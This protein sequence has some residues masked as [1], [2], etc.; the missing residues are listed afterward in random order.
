M[1]E[2]QKKIVVV[3]KEKA[4]AMTVKLSKKIKLDNLKLDYVV[5]IENGGLNVS[6]PLAKLLGIPHKSIKISFYNKENKANSE[7][8]VDFH[9]HKFEKTDRVLVVDDLIDDGHT[10]NYFENNVNCRHKTAVLYWNKYGKYK[11]TPDY[12]I[13]EKFVN[14][15]LEFYWEQ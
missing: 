13:E 8:I 10:I 9:G 15:W 11:V 6:V 1:I 4:D 7:P 5:G 2:A 14:T 12:F 3:S